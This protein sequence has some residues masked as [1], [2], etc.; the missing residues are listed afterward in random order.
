MDKT[1]QPHQIEKKWYQHWSQQ[2]HFKAST[3]NTNTPYCIMIPP[4]NVTGSL[5][6]GHGF[7]ITLIDT[8]IRYHR[9]M[10]FKTHWQVGTDHAGIATQMVVEKKCQR[11][12]GKT[13]RD[14]TRTTFTDKIWQ[15]KSES[16]NR[17]QDQLKRI[18]ASCDWS[19]N[20]F[21][22][23]PGLSHAVTKTFIDL[24]REDLIYRGKRLVN[25]DTALET[26]VSD[27]E[28]INQEQSG[29]LWYFRYPVEALDA[30]IT[31]ATT[32]P[33]TM[34][35][36]TAV[37]VHPEDSRYQAF[38]GKQI[39]LPLSKRL[40]PIIS[41]TSVDPTFGSG[42]VKIT[43]AHDFNDYALGKRHQ[44]P[45]INLL[46]PNGTLN[47]NTP[48]PY[49][50]M[51][52]IKARKLIVTQLDEMG[53]LEKTVPHT[54][55]V[56]LG[57]QSGSIIE[58]YLTDQWFVAMKSLAQPAIDAV[59]EKQMRFIPAVWENTYFQW[60]E[61][62]EDWC[63]SRQL[64][65]GHRI[66]AWYDNNNNC[67]VGEDEAAVR[68]HYDLESKVQLHQ[69]NDVLDTWFSSA[70]W[71]FASLGWPEKTLDLTTFYPTQVLVTGFDIIFFW[72]AR[73]IMMGLKLTK[74]VPFKDIYITGLIRD[75][76]GQKMSKSKGNVIDPIDLVDGISL[77][78]LL[79]KRT[80]NM[81]QPS[82][83]QKTKKQTCKEFPNGIASFGTDALRFTYCA[84]AT[85]GRDIRFDLSRLEGYRNFCNKIWNATRFVLMQTEGEECHFDPTQDLTHLSAIDHWI[86][87]QLQQ[88]IATVH[89]H[90]KN[91]RF[92]LL[93]QVLYEFSWESYCDWYLELT[94]LSLQNTT[95]P[96]Q[97]RVMLHN[98]LSV[99]EQLLR[100][101]HPIIP[102]ITEEIWQKLQ[103]P[104]NPNQPSTSIM[105]APFP[106]AANYASDAVN[107][108]QAS[109]EITWLKS[110]ITGIRNIRGEMRISPSL[111]IPLITQTTLNEDQIR[112][113]RYAPLL[114]KITKLSDITPLNPDA[115]PPVSATC[116]VDTLKLMIPL[117][118]LIDVESEL[119]RIAKQMQKTEHALQQ[120]TNKLRNP[121]FINHAPQ[122]VVSKQQNHFEELTQQ[123]QQLAAEQT[124]LEAL[125]S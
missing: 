81:M 42:A 46:N 52:R 17:I 69:D 63:I 112:I 22:L 11:E 71:P 103:A 115:V 3:Q 59:K 37:A 6:M 68:K 120:V 7:Q 38:I 31:I 97:K 118:G 15:W 51:D 108:K 14:Y 50:G 84:L 26:A 21:T 102:F 2:N 123:Q 85:T 72:V 73:M 53:L 109:L 4:P 41:D 105:L 58:P 32:R 92:D 95:H 67:Y 27:L 96:D 100:L 111:T 110:V 55:N 117:E 119:K 87:H 54:L 104:L 98:L 64:W 28:V 91:Y 106:T 107:G 39:R 30:F 47:Q 121:K 56:P 75:S 70:L 77:D 10:G 88:T 101:L 86:N 61:N 57:E 1:Y 24:Y 43:P 5:H 40:I 35:G 122:A 8:L 113:D 19:K 114:K 62:I 29:S 25:W 93:A 89:T 34:L 48:E 45:I 60:L 76:D 9:M 18:G 65:W 49:Q 99:L 74:Q 16:G 125:A 44:L 80:A 83:A 33:E 12:E 82:L 23:D 13:R 124:K 66:P 90:L 36:D 116:H 20:R 79:E 78:D 94:K